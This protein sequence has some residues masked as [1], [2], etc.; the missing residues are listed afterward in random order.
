MVLLLALNIFSAWKRCA[1]RTGPARQ[2]GR[3]KHWG[4]ESR[5]RGLTPSNPLL[6][7]GRGIESVQLSKE[8]NDRIK[9]RISKV[10]PAAGYPIVDDREV[11][12]KDGKFR[13]ISVDEISS[14][15]TLDF[16]ERDVLAVLVDGSL[17]IRTYAYARAV[18]RAQ[19]RADKEKDGRGG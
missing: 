8:E 4:K 17:Q 1:L 15:L 14:G 13:V 3:G 19:K 5:S 10:L 7:F 9:E 11:E 6:R 16:Y 18:N 12:G 2:E